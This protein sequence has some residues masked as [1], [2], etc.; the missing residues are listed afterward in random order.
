MSRYAV[1]AED[2]REWVVDVVVLCIGHYPVTKYKVGVVKG[3][4]YGLSPNSTYYSRLQNLSHSGSC[5]DYSDNFVD[6]RRL[7]S[8][9]SHHTEK[10]V[11]IIGSCYT[12]ID[13]ALE[14]RRRL[15][16]GPIMMVCRH[17][18]L[19]GLLHSGPFLHGLLEGAE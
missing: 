14:L 12:A 16:R 6:H 18:Y 2:G 9:L 8:M 15:H 13:I 5:E 1:Y 19:T 4:I 17:G 7:I 11:A 3:S 10:S